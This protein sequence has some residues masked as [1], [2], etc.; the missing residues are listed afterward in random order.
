VAP[1][2]ALPIEYQFVSFSNGVRRFDAV[3]FNSHLA[4][5]ASQ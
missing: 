4:A 3:A 5:A 2:R 1:R